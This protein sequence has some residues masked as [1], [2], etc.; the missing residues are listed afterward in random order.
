MPDPGRPAGP[1]PGRP[2]SLGRRPRA[3][4]PTL[5]VLA[6]LT[7]LS[8]LF[9][10]FFTDL[11]WFRAIGYSSVFTTELRTKIFL[12]VLFGAIMAAAVA[13]TIVLAYRLRP[14]YR[15]MSLEQQS[16]DRYRMGLQPY[17]RVVVPLVAGFIGLL[18]GA[19]ASGQWRTW[20]LWRNQ[21]PFGVQDAQFGR[22]VGFFAFSYPWWRF[23]LGF[24]FAVVVLCL[25][26]AAVT[27]YLYGG[28][29]LQTPGDKTT[30]VARTHLSVLIGVFVLLKAVAYWLDRFGLA[31]SE[32]GVVTGP[33]FTDVNA[34]LPA[35]TILTFIALI[36]AVLFF[37]SVLFRGWQLPGVGLGLLVLSAVLLGGVWPAI[38]QQFQVKPSEVDREQ[39]FIARNIEATRQAY[40]LDK[41]QKDTYTPDTTAAPGQ[42]RDDA[43]TTASVRLLDPTVLPPTYTQLQQVRGFYEFPDALDVDRY[44][45][46]GEKRDM[47][48]AVREVD[49]TGVPDTQK[50]W[51]NLATVYTHGFGFVAAPGNTR[52]TEG[53]PVFVEGGLP[54]SNNLAEYE[55]RIYY[56]ETSPA[57][58]VVGAPQGAPNREFDLPD[59]SADN[60][61]Q[62]NTYAGKGGVPIGSLFNRL[63]YAVKFQERNFIL[64]NRLNDASRVMYIRNPKDRVARVAPWL[65]LDGDPYPAIVDGRIQWIV[66]GYTT[67]NGYPYSN[68][69]TLG[70]ATTDSLT[71]TS[72]AVIAR[73]DQVNYIRNSVKAT[74]DAYDG[75]VTLYGWDESDPVLRTWQQA[76]PGT[77]QPR[78]AMSEE[79]LAHVRYP[80]DLFKVQRELYRRYHVTDAVAFYGGQDFWLVPDDPVRGESGEAQ[81]PYYLTIRMPDQVE[82]AFSLTSVYVPQRRQALAAFMAVN[83]D[84]GEDYGTI[85]VLEL[86]TNQQIDGPNQIRNQFRSD[87]EVGQLVNILERGG[88]QVEFGNLLTLPVGGGLLYVQPVYVAATGENETYPLL[89]KVLVTFGDELAFEDTLQQ[90]LDKVFQGQSGVDTGEPPVEGEEPPPPPPPPGGGG[91]NAVQQ[92]LADAQ[93]AVQEGQQALRDQ[94]FAAY[95]EAQDRLAEALQR[96]VDAG[97]D[98]SASPG[99][100]ASPTPDGG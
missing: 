79:L 80:E 22:D 89:R 17:H 57:Y 2:P 72:R 23:V 55:P 46:D 78:S 33:S 48:V 76:F 59:D 86:P 96:A 29:R 8:G 84:A 42:L 32:R 82:P 88:S 5:V 98:A 25:I 18:A 92:A 95:G 70:E 87:P 11:L 20:L 40:G 53:R 74:V 54:P 4:V 63:L 85:R 61:Q 34:M 56:G 19:S 52:D 83:A 38:V 73:Q 1:P 26:A 13:A 43:D 30:H 81:P 7:S 94:D 64:S 12:F 93:Q 91:G 62:N 60:G 24:A 51:I 45:L 9:T 69:T 41:V 58:S 35:K 49:L 100:T 68:R 50:N 77:V 6:I 21:V 75:T 47:V 14:P 27:H 44:M 31:F 65:T 3:L 15:A 39:P 67:S 90:A 97:G 99:A 28:I 16:L 71:T 36:C 10:N 66:D 37:A